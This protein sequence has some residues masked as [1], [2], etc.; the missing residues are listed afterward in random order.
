MTQL[1]QISS[2]LFI[3]SG[4]VAE[5]K[6]GINLNGSLSSSGDIVATAFDG[7]STVS[8]VTLPTLNVGN[9]LEDGTFQEWVTSINTEIKITASGNFDTFCFIKNLDNSIEESITNLDVWRTIEKGTSNG[10]DKQP[11]ITETFSSPGVYEY[12]I[13]ASN[14]GSKQTVV[15]GTTVTVT[16]K[17][18]A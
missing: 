3:Q 17:P 15:K 12:L 14:T 11:F 6:N 9:A 5:F 18:Q 7:I 1:H 8:G 4:S 10:L 13:I 2:S 16:D